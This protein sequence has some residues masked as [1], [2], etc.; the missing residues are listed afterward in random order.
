MNHLEID[1]FYF[2]FACQKNKNDFS[3]DN[4]EAKLGNLD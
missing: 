4:I 1:N 2:I 3:I